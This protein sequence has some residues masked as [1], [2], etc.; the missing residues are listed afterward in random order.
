MSASCSNALS[1]LP[2]LQ[3]T[4]VKMEAFAQRKLPASD[5]D[6]RL[7]LYSET[8]GSWLITNDNPPNEQDSLVI[9]VL[10]VGEY[11][12][13]VDNVNPDAVDLGFEL[14]FSVQ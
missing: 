9:G 10:P 14:D 13:I 3:E 4:D 7:S 12:V 6:S 1:V 2:S 5:V 8:T 11:R